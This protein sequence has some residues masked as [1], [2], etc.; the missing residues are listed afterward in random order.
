MYAVTVVWLTACLVLTMAL[1]VPMTVV[2][3]YLV[4]MM[5]TLLSYMWIDVWKFLVDG[6]GITGLCFVKVDCAS[7]VVSFA[8]GTWAVELGF[9][10]AVCVE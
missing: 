5:W 9:E 4:V 1:I 10:F 2:N 6:T 3:L 7:Y 8:V